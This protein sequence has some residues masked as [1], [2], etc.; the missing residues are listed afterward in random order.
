MVG[1]FGLVS[2]NEDRAIELLFAEH[3]SAAEASRVL[4]KE[5]INYTPEQLR[6]LK[7]KQFQSL[8]A[9]QRDE[10]M[11]EFL[12]DSVKKV[13]LKFEDLYSQ[14]ERL[15]KKLEAEGESF[16]QIIVLKELRSM[17]SMALK[18]LGEY[19]SGI[20]RIQAKNVNIINNSDIM[21]AIKQNQMRMF[22]KSNPEIK[23][24]KLIFNNPAPE[25]VDAYYKWKFKAGKK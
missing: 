6:Y 25:L 10:T 21:I 12:L 15:S 22:A 17:L 2:R 14:F 8:V 20:E 18:R 1:K 13:I 16:Q 9:E 19:K 3:L 7:Q 5:G 23:D 11:A 24:G 4:A